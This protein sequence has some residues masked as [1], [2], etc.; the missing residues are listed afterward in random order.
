VATPRSTP[1]CRWAISARPSTAGASPSLSG[2]YGDR[3]VA[4]RRPV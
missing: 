1:S 3:Q 4:P 2:A